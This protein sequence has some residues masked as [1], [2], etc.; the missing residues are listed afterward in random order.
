MREPRVPKPPPE[1]DPREFALQLAVVLQRLDDRSE[2]AVARVE[3]A[4]DALGQ[5][6]RSAAQ[7]LGAE[8][9]KLATALGAAATSR[10]RL[11]W[12]VSAALLVAAA[13]AALGASLAVASAQRE[14]AAV[15][16]DRELLEAIGRADV[17]LCGE[18][19]CARVEQGG[20]YRTVEL[21]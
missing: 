15:A 4:C 21:R 17:S 6:S 7:A 1:L 8:R 20:E 5:T 11:Q 9:Q 3:A 16:A 18:R 19:L 12:L 14:L 10:L 13:L 2:G